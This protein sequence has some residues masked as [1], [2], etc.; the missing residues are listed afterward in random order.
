MGKEFDRDLKPAFFL[1]VT[2]LPSFRVLQYPSLPSNLPLILV[3]RYSL[4][5][6]TNQNKTVR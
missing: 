4:L 5:P 2:A 3:H 1:A 6:G